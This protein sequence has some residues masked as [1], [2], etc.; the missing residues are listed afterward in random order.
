MNFS[1]NL[2]DEN[3]DFQDASS[4]IGVGVLKKKKHYEL[5]LKFKGQK[6]GFSIR[7]FKNWGWGTEDVCAML[8]AHTMA[9]KI[10]DTWRYIIILKGMM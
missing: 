8:M 9:H 6:L 7:I 2:K 1:L 10:L 5:F 3:G 4:K